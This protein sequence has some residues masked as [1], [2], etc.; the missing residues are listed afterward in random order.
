MKVIKSINNNI[1]LCLSSSGKEIIAFGK[2]IGFGKPPY[3]I[4]LKRIEKTFQNVQKIHLDLINSIPSDVLKIA[5]QTIDYAK[6][7]ID[8]PISNN[9]A[10]TLADHINFTIE[11]YKKGLAINLPIVHD[12]EY[13]Y[14]Q[15]IEVGRKCLELIKKYLKVS[16]PK[17]E[18]AY[19]ALHIIN[20]ES[21]ASRDE[22]NIN[23]TV[24]HDITGIIEEEYNIE[25]NKDDAG[26][27]RFETHMYYLLK[28]GKNNELIVSQNS[29]MYESL[30]EAF[31]KTEDCIVRIRDYF[32]DKLK[33]ELSDE[34]CLYLMIH[35]NK[36]CTREDC[37]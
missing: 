32:K 19:I 9:I 37:N 17:T 1:A 24:I 13:L 10:I 12:I 26:Y 3:E 30:K 28:R 2:G 8:Q 34:E 29:K 6:S 36:L 14:E 11:R 16:L 15:E 5:I 7:I 35:I 4:E 23:E 25:L 22:T 31:P 27:S 33:I 21:K 18:A 20:A